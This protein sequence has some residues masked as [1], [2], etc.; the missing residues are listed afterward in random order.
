MA[1]SNH[2]KFINN[3]KIEKEKTEM[4]QE[5]KEKFQEHY[6]SVTENFLMKEEKEIE[7]FEIKLNT[8]HDLIKEKN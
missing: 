3:K 8:I 5:E 6:K 2:S 1:K 4:I 7:L